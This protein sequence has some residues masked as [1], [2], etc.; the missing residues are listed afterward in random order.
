MYLSREVELNS[1]PMF[2]EEVQ[3]FELC[4]Q[5]GVTHVVLAVSYLSELMETAL[6]KEEKRVCH[7]S[8]SGTHQL[9]FIY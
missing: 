4:P 1:H 5:A 2:S 6:K 9:M 7:L 8:F 3:Y